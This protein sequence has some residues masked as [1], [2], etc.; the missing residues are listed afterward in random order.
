MVK[1][2]RKFR[3]FVAI[4]EGGDEETGQV[5]FGMDFKSIPSVGSMEG[6][7]GG[8]NCDDPGFA[9]DELFSA[10]GSDNEPPAV[11][12]DGGV[13]VDAPVAAA[14]DNGSNGPQSP[15][16][17]SL[18]TPPNISSDGSVIE[19]PFEGI[20]FPGIFN[21]KACDSLG[22]SDAALFVFK[23]DLAPNTTFGQLLEALTKCGFPH[24]LFRKVEVTYFGCRD[25]CAF[26][27]Y[28]HLRY[29][30]LISDVFLR[31]LSLY[32]SQAI[33]AWLLDGLM[34]SSKGVKERIAAQVESATQEED[35]S[36]V[37]GGDIF[38][39]LGCHDT[40]PLASNDP[41]NNSGQNT[42]R[43]PAASRTPSTV[44]SGLLISF[45]SRTLVSRIT[46]AAALNSM[47]CIVRSSLLVIRVWLTVVL[48]GSHRTSPSP[49]IWT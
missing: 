12:S 27:F 2:H 4:D 8:S 24:F 14:S 21:I 22:L 23:L 40:R 15:D 45:T 28:H 18:G 13:P 19:Q 5:Q 7:Y 26:S 1:N 17:D 6:Q 29:L 3:V 10:F 47:Q 43:V 36:Q 30:S 48:F 38:E 25:S 16:V 9:S 33:S 44:P 42:Q 34:I 41:S 11:G 31:S 35:D 46:K 49:P 37:K 32:S 20:S 39:L